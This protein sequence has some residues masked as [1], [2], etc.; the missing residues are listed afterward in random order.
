MAAQRFSSGSN[1]CKRVVVEVIGTESL[2]DAALVEEIADTA[3]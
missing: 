2:G 1:G 3:A